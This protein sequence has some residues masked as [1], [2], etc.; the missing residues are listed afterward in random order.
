MSCTGCNDGCF[1]ESV[2][3]AAGPTGPTGPAGSTELLTL[4]TTTDVVAI[5]PTGSSTIDLTYL[6]PLISAS[7]I[8]QT[9]TSSSYGT[10]H[11]DVTIPANTLVN[12][13][14]FIRLNFAIIGDY[15][16]TYIVDATNALSVADKY[17]YKISLST[18]ATVLDT[19]TFQAGLSNFRLL[20]EGNFDRNACQMT[21][22]FI[23]TGA[24]QLTPVMRNSNFFVGDRTNRLIQTS[25]RKSNS[26]TFLILSPIAATL[27][28]AFNLRLQTRSSDNTS[29]V[30]VQFHEVSKFIKPQ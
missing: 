3:L 14:E 28:G 1:D 8:E 20:K 27:S 7:V 18:G 22:D 2:Q 5:G 12:D 23:R 10:N 4:T 26:P 15:D 17:D 6:R 11:I 21:I 29:T 25:I 9:Q 13:G 16:P 24:S 19:Q 30:G